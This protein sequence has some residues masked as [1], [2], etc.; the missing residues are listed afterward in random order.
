MGSIK[1]SIVYGVHS[2]HALKYAGKPWIRHKVFSP[3]FQK[4]YFAKVFYR[5]SFFT[6]ATVYKSSHH[7][8]LFNLIKNTPLTLHC[9]DYTN[10]IS[11]QPTVSSDEL[12][13]IPSSI[14]DQQTI[15]CMTHD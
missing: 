8:W 12:S 7:N 4:H 13:F 15:S 6:I 10:Q 5:Q 14:T 3:M 9:V 1:F 11:V 2:Y